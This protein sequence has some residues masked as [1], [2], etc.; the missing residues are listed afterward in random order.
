MLTGRRYLAA[1]SGGSSFF[2]ATNFLKL[3]KLR[4]F[5]IVIIALEML[6]FSSQA[7]ALHVTILSAEKADAYQEFSA[8]FKAEL[9]HHNSG[10]NISESD[11]LP[12]VTDLIIAVGIK[13]ALIAS[14]GKF[15]VLCV[16][17]SKAG[18]QKFISEL[19]ADKKNKPISAIYF[20]QPIKRQIALVA[21]ALP[22]ARNIGLLYSGHSVDIANYR[23]AIS[24]NG[25]VVTEQKLESAES[26]FRE[27]ETVLDKSSVLLTIP[28]VTI[29]NS[30][31]IRNI[32]LTT[33]R[34]K[35][36]VVGLSP[37]YVRAGALFAV[38]SSPEQIAVQAANMSLRFLASGI[39]PLSQ[40]PSD[41]NVTSNL[42]VA[43]SLGIRLKKDAEIL[44]E[45]KEAENFDRGGE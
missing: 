5:L 15:S 2:S 41:F 29:Y 16:L 35:I 21:A 20:D 28:D 42:Q 17:V 11:T 6:V 22:D 3:Y 18:F 31:T 36:P 32:L 40:Y 45:I 44:K 19:P 9:L 33:Y 37:A 14:E 4:H 7:E 39:L 43:R 10:L 30:F 38:S 23:K 26:L 25:L 1:C 27:L 8:S 12:A 24:E 13:A 34:Y